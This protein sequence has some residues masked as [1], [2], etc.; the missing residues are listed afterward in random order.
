MAN[1]EEDVLARYAAQY[2]GATLGVRVERWDTGHRQGAHDLR[3]E[4]GGRTVAVEVKSVVDAGFRQMGAEIDR[5]EYQ[6]CDRL[7][8]FWIISVR[9]GA[10]IRDLRAQL[11]G[12]L[13]LLEDVGY[14]GRPL[15]M[16]R[17]K[18]PT[19]AEW[20]DE[21]GVRALHPTPPTAVHPGGFLLLPEPWGKFG[22]DNLDDIVGF[23]NSWFASGL[24]EVRKLHR[25]LR[26]A[27]ADERHAFLF[28]GWEYPVV[29]SL[30]RASDQYAG[31]PLPAKSPALPEPI[32]GVWLA[33]MSL[34]T[35][36]IAWLPE[37]AEW[38][39]GRRGDDS[40]VGISGRHASEQ[41]SHSS[42]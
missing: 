23:V 41:T 19:V 28:V 15:W 12:L 35:R 38:I 21:L 8:R 20:L 7:T 29:W 26:D 16:L 4:A 33:S 39:E 10:M 2:I 22:D 25:Q 27:D 17:Q 3:Y 24:P 11:P 34:L 30:N 36:V 6:P 14:E 42:P 18:L 9:H 31:A 40:D 13:V 5:Q 32:N 1:R 37:R